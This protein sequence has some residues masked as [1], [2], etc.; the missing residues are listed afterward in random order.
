MLIN[1]W[2]A[3]VPCCSVATV[4]KRLQASGIERGHNSVLE[5]MMAEHWPAKQVIRVEIFVSSASL[6]LWSLFVVQFHAFRSHFLGVLE[7]FRCLLVCVSVPHVVF[8]MLIAWISQFFTVFVFG[9]VP[10]KRCVGKQT[11]AAPGM[12]LRDVVWS[13]GARSP[14]IRTRGSVEKSVDFSFSQLPRHI[15]LRV[16]AL[17]IFHAL[18]FTFLLSFHRISGCFFIVFG[19][20]TVDPRDSFSACHSQRFGCRAP[21]QRSIRLTMTGHRCD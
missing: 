9:C 5:Y 8:M 14:T 19:A 10:L 21:F 4:R 11:P 12:Q 6:I 7:S 17:F 1:A 3:T 15:L 2:V 18:I 16:T 20:F 13:D